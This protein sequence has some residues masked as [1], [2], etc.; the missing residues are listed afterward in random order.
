MKFGE[1]KNFAGHKIPVAKG[2]TVYVFSDGFADQFGGPSGKKFKT[3]SFKQL[4]L[5]SQHLSMEEQGKLLNQTIEDWR[6][7]HEQ[8][9]DIL[10]IGTRF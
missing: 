9:D 1:H 10:V 7:T 6:G 8:V 5:S 2:D 3:S 4:L